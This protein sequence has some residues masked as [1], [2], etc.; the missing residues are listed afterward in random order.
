MSGN[1]RPVA[2]D[3]FCGAGG[4][5]LGFEAAG[6]DVAAAVDA[7]P[8]HVA[9]YSQNFP[10]TRALRVD[11]AQVCGEELRGLA[12]LAS[13][14]IDVVFGGPPCQGFSVGGRRRPDDP[15]NTLLGHFARLVHELRPR[16][17]VAENVAG[18][19]MERCRTRLEGFLARLGEAG[20]SVATPIGC[21]DAS[22]F[23]VPQRRGRVFLIG[24]RNGLPC[25][26]YPKPLGGRD[27][28]GTYSPPT[29]WHAIGDLPNVDAFD[30]LLG[31]D[32][33][34]GELDTPSQ[35]AAMLRVDGDGVYEGRAHRGLTGCGRTEHTARTRQR[36]AR[37]KPGEYEPVSRFYRLTRGGLA[38]TL[39]AGTGPSHGSYTAPRPIHPVWHRCITVREAA[40]LHS[41]PDWFEFHPTKWHGFRQIGNSV[42]PLLARA[43]AEAV[44]AAM[45]APPRGQPS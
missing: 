16:Y 31:S 40:R 3:L 17:F 18:L 38:P 14:E 11:L 23:G 15:R 2:M 10:Y 45:H 4:M 9:T 5:S 28:G 21:L 33:Y 1:E 36:F 44:R 8:V 30:Y 25:P 35:Y 43:V 22:E 12:G 7:D 24:A 20:Y 42:P 29:V 34:M 13:R 19:L 26:Q 6:F 39:R 41:F 37:T 32:L 27:D